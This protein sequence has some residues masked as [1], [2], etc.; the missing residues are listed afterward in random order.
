MTTCL[1]IKF[2]SDGNLYL[3]KILDGEMVIPKDTMIDETAG[4]EEVTFQ[5]VLI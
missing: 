1:G 5:A 4:R 2:L 3:M